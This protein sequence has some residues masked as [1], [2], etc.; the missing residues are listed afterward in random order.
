MSYELSIDR[1]PGEHSLWV[2]CGRQHWP[3]AQALQE[4]CKLGTDTFLIKDALRSV[5][6]LEKSR[7]SKGIRDKVTS[8]RAILEAE[9]GN[10]DYTY[11]FYES[12]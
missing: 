11:K 1:L 12:Y 9:V 4:A 7:Y 6:R 10:T 5:K 3:I 8:L 2:L